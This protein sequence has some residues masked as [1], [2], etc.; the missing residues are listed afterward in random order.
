M[1]NLQIAGTIFEVTS[2]YE[3][4]HT[5]TEN[6][7]KALD[8]TRRENIRNNRAKF[9]KEAVEAGTDFED[10]QAQ[11][12]AYADGY[13]FGAVTRGT[14]MDPVEKLALTLA[15]KEIRKTLKDSG[16]ADNPEYDKDWIAEKAVEVIETQPYFMEEAGRQI[17]AKQEAAKLELSL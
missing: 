16:V 4:G 7:A 12:T 8:Q 15:R 10:I 17:E 14:A 1:S 3:A 5:L 2:V 9:V 13:E 11:V 6:E